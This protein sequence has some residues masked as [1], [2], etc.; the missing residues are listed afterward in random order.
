MNQPHAP[1]VRPPG[2]DERVEIDLSAILTALRRSLR[3]IVPLVVGAVILTFVILQFVPARYR[4]ESKVLIETSNIVYPGDVRGAEEERA[5]L[6]TEGVASQV[7]LLQSRDLMRRV[8]QR[9]DLASVPEFE[10]GSSSLVREMFVALGLMRDGDS[11]TREERVLKVFYDNLEVFRVDGSR[12]ISVRYV[13]R[14]PE[15][16]ARVANAVVEE[17]LDLQSS[18]KRETTDIAAASLEP[19]IER[20]REEVQ[21]AQ[22]RA[23]D[24]RSKN[25][26]L[27]GADNQTLDRQ[28][29]GEIGTQLSDARAA[30]SQAEARAKLIRSQLAGGGSL[31]GMQDVLNS[32]L[33][34]RLRE[35][36]VELQARI[37][38]L[39]TTLLPNHPQIRALRSQLDDFERQIRQEAGRVAAGLENEA[40][41]Q[42]ER[43]ASLQ[44]TLEQLKTRAARSNDDQ[45][46]LRD[47][48][49][50][51]AVKATQLDQLMTRYR[52]ADTR[53]NATAIG[54]DARVISRATVPLEPFSPKVPQTVAI[55]AFVSLMLSAIAV[56]L[57]VFVSGRA[58]VTR[59]I[60]T[61]ETANPVAAPSHL[62][63]GARPSTEA[64]GLPTYR[65]GASTFSYGWSA[66]VSAQA[67]TAAST[68]V[69]DDTLQDAEAVATPPASGLDGPAAAP[70]A[71]RPRRVAVLSVDSDEISQS[72]TFRLVRAAAE[73]GVMP[74]FLEV[75]P[76]LADPEAVPGF[77]ELLDGTASFAGV[78]YRD[79]A[80]R[81]HV[82]E[83]GRRAIDDELAQNE[84]FEMLMEAIDHTYDQVFFDLGLIDDSLISAQILAMAD[85]VVVASG[86]SPADPEMEDA[87]RMLEDQTGAPVIVETVNDG[88]KGS[89][90]GWADMAA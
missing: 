74:L 13:S 75:R 61:G 52:E 40:G 32:Q 31:D 90:T 58:F 69:E 19:Q 60:E 22:K 18:V 51:A 68:D 59:V 41:I 47:L 86:G 36:Q 34:Q 76:D 50:E 89:G 5:L 54:A 44:A 46:R 11:N 14:D 66:P 24:F 9:L 28:Q 72:V 30:Q 49:R 84:R 25:D 21:A 1:D 3:W 26:L 35:R 38:E 39:S 45:V 4:A 15:L 62:G 27:L 7:E 56:I 8:A 70:S 81:A 16:A 42:Q 83:A 2:V 87:M 64:A 88:T 33:I 48:E 12:V 67:A 82:I 17:Y 43:V 71:A 63:S 20:L 80:S 53:R 29:L 6:D 79:A 10:A 37:A 23:E 65:A 77:A 85:Q 57:G 55:A 78:I 73:E